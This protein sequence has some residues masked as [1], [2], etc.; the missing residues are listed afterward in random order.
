MFA[1][2]LFRPHFGKISFYTHVKGPNIWRFDSNF[3]RDSLVT[4][5]GYFNVA[6]DNITV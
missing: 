1:I 3:A 4:I 2:M 5:K 6:Y